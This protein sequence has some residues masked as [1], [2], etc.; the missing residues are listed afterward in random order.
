MTFEQQ[1]TQLLAQPGV[2]V[3][4]SFWV[5]FWKGLALW[6]SAGKKQLAW[7]IILLIINTIGILEIVYIFYLNRWD[8]DKGRLLK[9]LEKKTK[10]T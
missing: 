10:K 8:I 5:I 9:F 3:I 4:I 6:K 2:L 1:I 7:F